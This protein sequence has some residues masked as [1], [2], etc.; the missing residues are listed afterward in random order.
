ML[1]NMIVLVML[2]ASAWSHIVDNYTLDVDD[3]RTCFP[4][5]YYGET[6]C[7]SGACA[8]SLEDCDGCSTEDDCGYYFVCCAG[9]CINYVWYECDEKA[10][11]A[12]NPCAFDWQMCC[13]GVCMNADSGCQ[14]SSTSMP[15]CNEDDTICND[16]GFDDPVCCPSG[17]CVESVEDC[18][19]CST[20]ADCGNYE[21]CCAGECINYDYGCD[22]KT[23]SDNNHCTYAWQLCCDG[24]CVNA[25]SGC[26]LTTTSTSSPNCNDDYTICNDLGFRILFAVAGA[27]DGS[28]W[29]LM[30]AWQ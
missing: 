17:A 3:Q 25:D 12:N 26:Q 8:D 28:V 9:E 1:E 29:T 19:G 21:V 23:C 30:T 16:L 2:I 27:M 6:C 15:N 7:P 22:E 18:D 11:S 13:D 5:C 4:S 24:V 14:S 20:E 10:C